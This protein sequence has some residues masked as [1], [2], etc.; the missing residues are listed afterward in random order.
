MY[1]EDGTNTEQVNSIFAELKHYVNDT[2][3]IQ[4]ST[5][6][7]LGLN[8]WQLPLNESSATKLRT[9]SGVGVSVLRDNLLTNLDAGRHS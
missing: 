3:Q 5:T 2:S 8:Y 1:P 4:T 7:T 9:F 6:D